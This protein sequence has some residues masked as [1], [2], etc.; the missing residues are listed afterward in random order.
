MKHPLSALMK[1]PYVLAIIA[2]IAGI[3]GI[4]ISARF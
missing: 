4:L 3:V 2:G 1:D